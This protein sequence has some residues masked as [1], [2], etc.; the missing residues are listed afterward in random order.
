MICGSVGKPP[1]VLYVSAE[2]DVLKVSQGIECEEDLDCDGIAFRRWS[3]EWYSYILSIS[4]KTPTH[5]MSWLHRFIDLWNDDASCIP[6]GM[7]R[8]V[9]DQWYEPPE[10]LGYYDFPVPWSEFSKP[11]CEGPEADWDMLFESLM[12]QK[13][14]V[15]PEAMQSFIVASGIVSGSCEPSSVCVESG[16]INVRWEHGDRVSDIRISQDGSSTASHTAGG[17]HIFTEKVL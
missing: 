5:K 11:L 13:D 10:P 7:E 1:Y 4:S 3:P 8:S 9:I 2:L 17:I 12:S 15:S 14:E 16:G 6:V